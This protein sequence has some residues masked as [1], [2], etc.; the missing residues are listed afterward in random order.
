MNS[1]DRLLSMLHLFSA[2]RPRWTAEQAAPVLGVSLSTAYRYFRSLTAAGLL[3]P[4]GSSG[5][6]VL[7]PGII[8]LDRL[9]RISDPLLQA[10][11]QT[12]GWLA[13]QIE[14]E[15]LL[16]LC[17]RYH[18]QVMC[19]HQEQVAGSAYRSHYERGL[20]LP[21]FRGAGSKVIL[22]NLPPGRRSQY[23]RQ[24]DQIE[25]GG[26]AGGVEVLREELRQIRR[27]GFHLAHGELDPAARGLAV[28]LFD[29]ER[30]VL[31]S[32]CVVYQRELDAVGFTRL[33]GLLAAA[34]EEIELG[35][36][37]AAGPGI[38]ASGDGS[39]SRALGP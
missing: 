32:L 7:G 8:E 16:L 21:L 5:D 36:A 26:D 14:L 33:K 24:F 39:A 1:A 27:D 18:G 35:L 38:D 37:A 23:L 15:S 11:Q 34:A 25:A 2:D 12:M 9:L 4:V 30:A 10:A 28:P 29:P 22:A 19:I 3:T 17:R 20:P 31:G 13:S 6:Y